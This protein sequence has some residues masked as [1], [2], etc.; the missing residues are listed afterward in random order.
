LRVSRCPWMRI[1]E[2]R[3]TLASLYLQ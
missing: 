3:R 2:I 1:I